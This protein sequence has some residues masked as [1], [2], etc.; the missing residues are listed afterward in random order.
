MYI[1]LKLKIY[2]FKNGNS[3]IKKSIFNYQK[4]LKVLYCNACFSPDLFIIYVTISKKSEFTI[5]IKQ[6]YNAS[7]LFLHLGL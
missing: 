3:W 2:G 7:D 1:D 4:F 6:P 5:K